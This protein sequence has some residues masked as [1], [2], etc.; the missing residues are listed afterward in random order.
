M[1]EIR[2]S[3]LNVKQGDCIIFE[4]NTGRVSVIDICCGNL[5]TKV[6]AEAKRHAKPTGDYGMRNY[7]TN[8]IDYL[9]SKGISE[10]W[11]FIL[12]HPDMDH[13]DGIKKFFTD[14]KVLH[15]WDCGTRKDK[16]PFDKSKQYLEEDWNFYS[17]LISNK[18]KD[19]KLIT[20]RAG[21]M[22]KYWNADSDDNMGHGDY[23]S[24]VAPNEELIS[25]AN[26]SGSVNDASYVLVYRSPAG[27]IIFPGDSSDK[28]WEF[29]VNNYKSFVSDAAV[30][31]A[32]HHGRK[33][34]DFSF[35]DVVKPRVSFFGYAS[36]EHL[37]YSA[38]ANR[39]LLYF[40][41]NQCG[42]VQIY[43]GTGKVEVFI[44]NEKFA[45][46][47]TSGNSHQKD[48]YWFLCRV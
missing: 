8:P 11:R 1:A 39:E 32:P 30:L 35:L 26:K 29:I 41:N 28:T 40:T 46:D 3:Y 16:P 48:G 38:W 33:L 44:E 23:L 13:M 10:I 5:E 31:F 17:D 34:D 12:T 22:G 4:Q 14:K 19:T 6:I 18:V 42:N 36:S 37:A 9:T 24:I 15:F 20:P 47:Y 45:N 21:D 2:I 7:P 27:K 43:P 25:E